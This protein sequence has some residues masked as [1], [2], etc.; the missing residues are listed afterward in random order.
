MAGCPCSRHRRRTGAPGWMGDTSHQLPM[1]A[2]LRLPPGPGDSRCHLGLPGC[3]AA[4]VRFARRGGRCRSAHLDHRRPANRGRGAGG[5]PQDLPDGLEISGELAR[6]PVAVAVWLERAN[7]LAFRVRGRSRPRLC[8]SRPRPA[9]VGVG[10]ASW[11]IFKLGLADPT[12]TEA[13]LA[14]G[15]PWLG[16]GRPKGWR[17]ACVSSP[18]DG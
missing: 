5:A 2:L 7:V 15:A 6:S 12:L 14:A 16:T 10:G 9:V 4:S 8:R 3:A 18:V 13:G 11:G 1:T 17:R